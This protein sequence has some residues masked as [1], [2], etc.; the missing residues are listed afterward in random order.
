MT[1]VPLSGFAGNHI[2]MLQPGRHA[3]VVA[4]GEGQAAPKASDRGDLQLA[5]ILVMHRDAR[6]AVATTSRPAAPHAAARWVTALRH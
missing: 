6:M 5:A 1:L 2:W 4:P 3:T